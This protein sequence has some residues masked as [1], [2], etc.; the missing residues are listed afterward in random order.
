MK[1]KV[2]GETINQVNSAPPPQPQWGT[3]RTFPV[4]NEKM[5]LVWRIRSHR[6]LLSSTSSKGSST[7]A[8]IKLECGGTMGELPTT[9]TSHPE[10]RFQ[11]C[12]PSHH[13]WIPSEPLKICTAG[14]LKAWKQSRDTNCR[15]YWTCLPTPSSQRRELYTHQ[16]SIINIV[17]VQH[18]IDMGK[19]HFEGCFPCYPECKPAFSSVNYS[20]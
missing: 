2:N 20:D 15:S 5:L 19:V 6:T 10:R 11:Q 4:V 1:Q 14:A 9:P 12:R 13:P 7:P 3:R 17:I 16:L 8:A 18:D